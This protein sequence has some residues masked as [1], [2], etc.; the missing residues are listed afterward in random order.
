MV[1]E[2]N[3]HPVITGKGSAIFFHVTNDKY[4][5]TAGCVAVQER[6]MLQILSWLHPN[7]KKYVGIIL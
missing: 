1:I 4:S 2:Y 3:T 6:D 7:K 5:S